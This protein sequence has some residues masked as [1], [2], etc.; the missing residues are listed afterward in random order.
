VCGARQHLVL[1]LAEVPFISSSGI[2]ALLALAEDFT[3][4]RRA[5]RIAA[6]SPAVDSVLRLLNLEGFLA[7]DPTE[8]DS[9]QGLK[10]A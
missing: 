7:L 9:V 10:A 6:A 1:N 3:Q 8:A 4:E 5:I 2:G